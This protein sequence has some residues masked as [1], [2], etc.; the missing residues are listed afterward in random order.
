MI[1][2]WHKKVREAAERND[3]YAAFMAIASMSYMRNEEISASVD[4]A[5]QDVMDCF[6]PSDLH[7]TFRRFEQA[8]DAYRAEYVRLGLPVRSYPDADSF[9]IDYLS[10]AE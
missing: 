2:N 3:P 9:V 4:I 5:P 8:L 6:D 10:G 1:S 7:G